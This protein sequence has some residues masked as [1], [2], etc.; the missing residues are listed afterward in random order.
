MTSA[1]PQ[2]EVLAAVLYALEALHDATHFNGS[3]VMANK[4]CCI[5]SDNCVRKRLYADQLSDVA[6]APMAKL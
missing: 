5:G 6:S 3:D 4:G 1:H 2:E